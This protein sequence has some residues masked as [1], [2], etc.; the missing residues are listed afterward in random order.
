MRSDNLIYYVLTGMFVLGFLSLIGL[1][2]LVLFAF[3]AVIFV[4]VLVAAKRENSKPVLAMELNPLVPIPLEQWVE[5]REAP[6][7]SGSSLVTFRLVNFD[8]YQANWD[9]FKNKAQVSPGETVRVES[10]L[11]CIE[12]SVSRKQGI[13][14]AYDRRVLAEFA[15]IDLEG[16]FM[17]LLRA[18]GVFRVPCEFVF[19]KDGEVEL[20][21]CFVEATADPNHDPSASLNLWDLWLAIWG[22]VR[23]KRV[24]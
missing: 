13:V 2:Y 12:D 7:S 11:Y 10:S 15:E 5:S 20:A 4:I 1:W 8:G 21:S 17:P 14:V 24:D 19:S 3:A 9:H 23:G 6:V 18:G 16:V 22:A